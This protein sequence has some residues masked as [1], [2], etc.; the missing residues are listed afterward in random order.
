[1]KTLFSLLGVA[2]V[3]SWSHIHSGEKKD[4]G[5]NAMP[6]PAAWGEG[7]GGKLAKHTGFAWYR[8]WVKV[9]VDWKG[10]DLTL[11]IDRVASAHEVY[12]EGSMFGKAGAFP[13]KFVDATWQVNSYSIPDK[14]IRPGEYHLLAVR[15]YS[16][17]GGGGIKGAPPAIVNEAVAISL[18]G[19]WQFRTGDEVAWAKPTAE[20]PRDL[21]LFNK[22]Q[23]T[24]S[25][26][27][28]EGKQGGF[29]P[30]EAAKNFTVAPDLRWDQVLAEPIVGQPVCIT[31]DERGRLW[32]VQYLQYPNPAGLKMLSRDI[33]WRAIYDKMSPP[34]PKHFRG[35]DKITIH[36]STRGDGVFD[37]HSTFVDGLNITTSVLP[38][39][40]GV[41]VL[42]PPYLLFYPSKDGSTPSGDPVVHVQGFGIEDTHSMASSLRWG[43]DG[44]IYGAHGSTVTAKLTSP[45][46][47][48][49]DKMPP[50][51]MVGQ[52]IWRYHPEKHLIEVFGEGGG[53]TFGVEFDRLGRVFSGHNGGNTRGF[54]YVQGGSYRKGFEK[55]GQL[56]NPFAFGFF[57]AMKHNTAQRFSHTFTFFEGTGLPAKYQGEMFAV[58]PLQNQIILA[59]VLPDA[60]SVQTKDVGPVV[61]T[62]DSWFRPVDITH[63]PEGAL[64]VADWYDGNVGHYRAHE[65]VLDQEM[66]RV[67]RLS[68]KDLK[69]AKA[70]D[71]G[72]KTTAELVEL[73]GH[74]ERWTRQTALR[75]LG[76]SMTALSPVNGRVAHRNCE[77]IRKQAMPAQSATR[78]PTA[79]RRR[80]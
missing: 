64:Y 69:P 41:W 36:E 17:G 38:G 15:V 26:T 80:A 40:G 19:S 24:A 54:H 1:M 28:I 33:Y 44:W 48:G 11:S 25:L 39:R 9:P 4:E 35:K 67:Y 72:K 79:R 51:V 42:N 14:L 46:A 76:R 37:K 61:A 29:K 34:P 16:A 27:K 18:Q 43:P 49:G 31:F 65:G 32:V 47:P 5:W 62:K 77:A 66:G 58:A 74:E 10:S 57:E 71:L 55:H 13:P 60:S 8:C 70:P 3:L 30:A 2:L 20:R 21:A 50:V 53:N 23:D 68:S 52:H 7:A 56:A 22:V 12:W 6:V 63:G 45:L 78:T 75:L 73:L 59:N